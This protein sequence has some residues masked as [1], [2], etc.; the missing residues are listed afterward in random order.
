MWIPVAA[1]AACAATGLAVGALVLGGDGQE[2]TLVPRRPAP[3]DGATP[4]SAAP[5]PSDV[6]SPAPSTPGPVLLG[7]PYMLISDTGKAADV[8]AASRDNGTVVIAYQ[9]TGNPDQRWTL[10]YAAAPAGGAALTLKGSGQTLG[11]GPGEALRLQQPGAG[12]ARKWT[13]RN[14]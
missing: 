8:T 7:G 12:P 13:V 9:P 4:G 11:I 1:I 5:S 2:A 10:T 3:A 6:P 14:P